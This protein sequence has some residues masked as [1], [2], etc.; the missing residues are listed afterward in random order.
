MKHVKNMTVL[1][2]ISQQNQKTKKTMKS[3][4]RMACIMTFSHFSLPQCKEKKMVTQNGNTQNL[5]AQ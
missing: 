3:I 5:M 4:M 2:C 1:Y